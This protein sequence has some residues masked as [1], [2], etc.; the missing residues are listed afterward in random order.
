MD[1][2]ILKIEVPDLIKCKPRSIEESKHWKGIVICMHSKA[3]VG[4]S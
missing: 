3:Q 1:Q 2:R 4:H